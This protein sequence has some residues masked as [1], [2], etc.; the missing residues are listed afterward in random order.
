M[1]IF[2][3]LIK[4]KTTLN[5]MI[6]LVLC[7]FSGSRYHGLINILKEKLCEQ[8]CH[9][10]QSSCKEKIMIFIFSYLPIGSD[11]PVSLG[12]QTRNPCVLAQTQ[13]PSCLELTPRI[14]IWTKQCWQAIEPQK[15]NI[16]SEP[17][18]TITFF[19]IFWSIKTLI[20]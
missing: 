15:S 17:E 6:S 9:H 14:C 2:C 5:I 8:I 18:T 7:L 3:K 1:S 19:Y 16:P 12:S 10:R 13:L 11:T 20:V 4:N